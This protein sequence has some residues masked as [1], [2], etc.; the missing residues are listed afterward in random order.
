MKTIYHCL[1]LIAY[2]MS[3]LIL[4]QSCIVYHKS[5]VTVDEAVATNN[6]VKIY[7]TENKEYKFKKLVK[8]EDNIY[9]IS[10]L[11]GRNSKNVFAPYVK[12]IDQDNNLVKILLPFDI[13]EIHTINKNGSTIA[14]LA[15]IFGPLL[16][17][18]AFLWIGASVA[19]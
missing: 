1:K 19:Y 6:L 4:M 3:A 14:T 5:P 2:A 11:D 16:A 8:E 17:I 7:T 9:G 18:T 10:S 12:E 13:K 15:V